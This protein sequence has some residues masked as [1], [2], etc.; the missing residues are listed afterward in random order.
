LLVVTADHGAS[1]RPAQSRR[2]PANMEH[3][4]DALGV[5]LFVK[6]AH[7]HEGRVSLRNVETID[8][9]PTIADLLGI[10][11]PWPIDGCSAVDPSC[12]PRERKVMYD[13]DDVRL[14]FDP[15]LPLR[16]ESLER[17]LEIFG[18]GSRPNGL[19]TIGPHRELVGRS[20]EKIGVRGPG[21]ARVQLMRAAFDRADQRPET[22]ALGRVTGILDR[23][24]AG[25]ETPYV[26]VAVEGTVHA[27]A[28]A[29]RRPHG[30]Y[31]FSAML[32]Q[33]AYAF[34]GARVEVFAVETSPTGPA[35]LRLPAQLATLQKVRPR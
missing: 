31:L 20:V 25:G 9:L 19:F 34:A 24:P 2:D 27:V 12:P 4:E 30:G 35:L 7:Q 14:S 32:P 3:P 15:D 10:G 29:F 5:P 13:R 8:I 18:S 11:I 16:R 21:G 1:F 22:F 33:H 26:A 17:K 23:N 28:P 6:P